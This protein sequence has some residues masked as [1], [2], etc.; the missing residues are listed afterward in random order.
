MRVAIAVAILLAATGVSQ[1]APARAPL[2]A[3]GLQA[4]DMDPTVRPQ[5]DL[6]AYA[7]GA[8]LRD[9]PIPPDRSRWG[10]DSM[11]AEQVL[12][13]Q[14]DLEAAAVTARDPEARKVG[15]LYASVMDEAAIKAAGL[16]PLAPELARIDRIATRR[17][18]AAALAHLDR[19]GVPTPVSTYVYPDAR[20]PD[21]YAL[22]ISED[23]LGLPDREAYLTDTPR[24]RTIRDAYLAY[25]A[26]LLREA[27]RPDPQADAARILAFET[28]LARLHW[29]PLAARDPQKTYN[30][31]SPAE[32]AALAPQLDWP[33][34]RRAQ[35]LAAGPA[36]LRIVVREPDYL[37]AVA[38]LTETTP[39]DTWKAY[40]R[41]RLLAM[42]APYL[43]RRFAD[44]DFAFNEQ[45]LHGVERPPARW[46][47]ACELVD[48]LMGEAA[49]KLYVARYFPPQAK[50]RVQGMTGHL[51]AAYA[52]A[53][54]ASDWMS[55]ATKAQA[56]AKLRKIR[57]KVG[58]PDRW[59]DYSALRI[60]P[61]DLLGNV[62]RA[63]AF[64]TD[65]KHAQLRGPVDRDEWPMTPATVDAAYS[66]GANDATFPAGILQLFDPADDAY[67][68]GNTG[69]SIGHELSHAFDSRGSQYDADGALRDW[70]TPDDRRRYRAETDKLVRQFDAFEPLPGQHLNGALTLSENLADLS[71]LSIAYRA[72]LESLNGRAPPV[73][74]GLTAPQRFFIGYAQSYLGKRR[75]GLLAAQ[76]RSNPHAPERYRVNGVVMNLQ[77]FDAAFAVQPGDALYLPPEA[78]VRLW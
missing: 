40:L 28:E 17:D 57:I 20:R 7:N 50:A 64:E 35:G 27:G 9:T 51:V 45:T 29:T 48:R 42:A 25:V 76:L 73:V 33:A 44:P 34:W 21:R 31:V 39:L 58:Y 77:A 55:P 23:G 13:Q 37:R 18:L 43:P 65:R 12:A 66:P 30:P 6:F 62:L 5:D 41:L 68:Y 16:A 19:I 49:G 75:D 26:T 3:P 53:I 4:Q 52:E 74:G 32:L 15:A 22:W 38:A 36:D 46:R 47:R 78:R 60:S 2:L 61:A 72:Y 8:W 69:A 14:R 10:I 11:L 70:W 1:A 59:R 24:A 63:Q 71:G 67:N 54:E 56:L